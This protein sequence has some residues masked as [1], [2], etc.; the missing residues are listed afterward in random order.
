MAEAVQPEIKFSTGAIQA[1]VWKNQGT[2]KSGEATEFR[3]ISFGRRYK[4]KEGNW[5]STN[6]LRIN[7]LPRAVIVLNK[8][9]E[10]LVLRNKADDSFHI[11]EED[12][13][14]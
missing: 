4:D 11:D 1:T 3:T 12:I 8:A 13:V 2:S 7:D 14:M 9:Y 10:Y 5:R 6:S